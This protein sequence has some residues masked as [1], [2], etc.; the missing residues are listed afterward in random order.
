[1]EQP[2]QAEAY[3]LVGGWDTGND[4]FCESK[5]LAQLEFED[6]IR[7]HSSH[8]NDLK[9]RLWFFEFHGRK[10]SRRGEGL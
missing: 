5:E 6:D 8:R 3:E 1:M 9:T 2:G 7:R 10:D 4:A